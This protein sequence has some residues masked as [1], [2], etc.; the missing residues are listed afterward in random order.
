MAYVT[1]KKER[2][3]KK[4]KI[5]IFVSLICYSYQGVC[6]PLLETVW[7]GRMWL[8]WYHHCFHPSPSG[9]K[10]NAVRDRT[11][12]Q[13]WTWTLGVRLNSLPTP[14]P[15]PPSSQIDYTIW[16]Q[17]CVKSLILQLHSDVFYF[18]QY[19]C[20]ATVW[21]QDNFA[22]PG[23]L[24]HSVAERDWVCGHDSARRVTWERPLSFLPQGHVIPLISLPDETRH[25][26]AQERWLRVLSGLRWSIV[27]TY[28]PLHQVSIDAIRC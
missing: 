27:E 20:V 11:A 13:R 17:L 9:S 8:Q 3:K 28:E 5:F 16:L 21:H 18:L 14:P 2:K 12:D 22:F 10:G 15:P 25:L 26:E 1:G 24:T 23:Y 7:P 4:K 19:N 6:S